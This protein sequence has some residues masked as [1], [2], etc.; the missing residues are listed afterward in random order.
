MYYYRIV[1]SKGTDPAKKKNN[2][3]KE[4]MV[5]HYCFLIMSWNFK[6]SFVMVVMVWRCC[7][8]SKIAIIS[9]KSVDYRYIIYEISKSEAI[10][11]LEIVLKDR[12]YI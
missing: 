5:C 11:L 9:V 4:Y 12:G 1:I 2:S 7:V 8:L 6:I 10:D 3:S